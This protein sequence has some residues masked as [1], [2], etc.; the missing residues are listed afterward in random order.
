MTVPPLVPKGQ[1]LRRAVVWLAEHR[2]WSPA[3]I[4]EA[5]LQ[6]DLSPAEEEFL[7]REARRADTRRQP[8][9]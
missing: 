7:L 3:R 1:A 5:S 6:F 8:G 9:A 2:D 4:D